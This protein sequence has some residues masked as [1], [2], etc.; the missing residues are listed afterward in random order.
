MT[1]DPKKAGAKADKVTAPSA[2]AKPQTVDAYLASLDPARRAAIE[3]VR[4]VILK[5]LPAG[6]EEGFGWGAITYQVPL[7]RYPNTYNGQPLGIAALASQKNYCSVY[8]M[9][10]YG[11]DPTRVW[12]EEEYARSGKRLDMGKSCVRFRNVD[13]LPLELIGQVIA[14]VG[15]DDYL[16]R[17]EEIR[18]KT[19]KGR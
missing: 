19:A 9:A 15:V 2:G 1:T 18:S 6:Y 11:H 12:F 4:G 5:N 10:V 3:T 14:K 7:S 8:L 17:Y 16:R 13:D